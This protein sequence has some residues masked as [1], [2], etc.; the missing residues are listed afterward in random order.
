MV[1]FFAPVTQAVV[2]LP[3]ANGWIFGGQLF[4][5][6]LDGA[7]IF[8]FRFVMIATAWHFHELAR[9]ADTA[10]IFLYQVLSSVFFLSRALKFFFDAP[11][12]CPVLK[13]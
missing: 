10:L 2:A 6:F 13:G 1:L 4:Q 9:L 11:F 7:V 3:K 8:L 12:H 5:G